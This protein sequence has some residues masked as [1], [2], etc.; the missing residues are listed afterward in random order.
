MLINITSVQRKRHRPTDH[1][2]EE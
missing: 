2:W 1:S